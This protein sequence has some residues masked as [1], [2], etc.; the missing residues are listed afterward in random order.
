MIPTATHSPEYQVQHEWDH[1]TCFCVRCGVSQ[2]T[3]VSGR[4]LPFCH[5]PPGE[6]AVNHIMA[7]RFFEPILREIYR[8]MQHE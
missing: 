4:A 2:L 3:C 7:R 6:I 5:A 1:Y 8:R